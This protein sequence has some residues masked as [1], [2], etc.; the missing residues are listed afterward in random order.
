MECIG[1][2]EMQ[3]RRERILKFARYLIR[4]SGISAI[5]IV[6]GCVKV[7]LEIH[8]VLGLNY[9]PFKSYLMRMTDKEIL[10]LIS[11]DITGK[12]YVCYNSREVHSFFLLAISRHFGPIQKL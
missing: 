10:K 6:T 12:L 4:H 9:V 11:V 3:N 2:L 1:T 7:C 8:T 5:N